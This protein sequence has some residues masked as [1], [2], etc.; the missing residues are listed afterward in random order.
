MGVCVRGGFVSAG[1]M[2]G[3]LG[4]LFQSGSYLNGLSKSY[5]NGCGSLQSFPSCS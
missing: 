3:D 2:V 4:G 1:L 5:L